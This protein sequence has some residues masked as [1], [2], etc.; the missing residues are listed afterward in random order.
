MQ[1]GAEEETDLHTTRQMTARTTNED[2]TMGKAS[3]TTTSAAPDDEKGIQ[4]DQADNQLKTETKR[5]NQFHHEPDTLEQSTD[6]SFRILRYN[7]TRASPARGAVFYVS[8]NL[9]AAR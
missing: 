3:E 5:R 7:L 8:I 1:K 2:K 9:S 6:N 4:P